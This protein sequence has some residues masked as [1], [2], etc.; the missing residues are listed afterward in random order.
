MHWPFCASKCPYC[1]FN[2]H[3][4][5]EVPQAAWREGLL[6]EARAAARLWPR[7]TLGQVFFGGGTPSL[8]PPETVAAL[9]EALFELWPPAPDVEVTLECNPSD[10]APALFDGLKAAGVGRLSLGVQSFDDRALRFLGR[11]HDGAQAM[12]ALQLATAR[13]QRVSADLICGLPEQTAAAWRDDLDRALATGIEHLSAYELTLEPGTP[14]FAAAERGRLSL[15]GEARMLALEEETRQAAGAAGL[16]RYEVSTGP[17]RGRHAGTTSPYGGAGRTPLS[18]PGPTGAA[19][20]QES[21]P[22]GR[23]ERGRTDAPTGR[24]E[25]GRRARPGVSLSCA[26]S[27]PRRGLPAL[28][29]W[30]AP[31]EAG[32]RKRRGA[33]HR[34]A[35]RAARMG[36]EGAPEAGGGHSGGVPDSLGRRAAGG[37]LPLRPAD[38]RGLGARPPPTRDRDARLRLCLGD[39]AATRLAELKRAGWLAEDERGLRATEAGLA[40]L[41]GVLARLFA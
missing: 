10:A 4:R 33:Q 30:R 15:P 27:R 11:R 39:E 31:R 6:A 14:F 22:T 5:R 28:A 41:D 12:R 25:R 32:A 35:R 29:L 1:D 8:M 16:A 18:G 24:R 9:L 38:M 13:F 40:R 26:R 17:S 2:S 19:S 37:V 23:R 3:V 20:G 36:A 21:A 34:G 7:Q